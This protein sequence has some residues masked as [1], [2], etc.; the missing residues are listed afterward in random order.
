L[1]IHQ[2]HQRALCP[3]LTHGSLDLQR[4]DRL[5]RRRSHERFEHRREILCTNHDS[6]SHTIG[7]AEPYTYSYNYSYSESYCY[8]DRNA[9]RNAAAYTLAEA[10]PDSTP[11]ALITQMI[12][13]LLRKMGVLIL[14]PDLRAFGSRQT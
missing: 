11:P 8:A 13:R 1:D 4:N 12:P 7:D 2:H 14:I 10:A 6:Y 5:G 3:R 9:Q